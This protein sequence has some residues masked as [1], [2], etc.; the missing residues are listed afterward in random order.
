MTHQLELRAAAMR[1]KNSAYLYR[2]AASSPTNKRA[3]VAAFS[4]R[5]NSDRKMLG[6]D[7]PKDLPKYAAPVDVQ[8]DL[9]QEAIAC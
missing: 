9:F 3:A 4:R 5:V 1:L 6:R 7:I 8:M 2:R